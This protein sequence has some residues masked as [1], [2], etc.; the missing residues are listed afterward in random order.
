MTQPQALG[1][2]ESVLLEREAELEAIDAA[3]QRALAGDGSL[4]V[5]AGHAGIGKSALLGAARLRAQAV[6]VDALAARGSQLERELSFGL[7][8][9]LFEPALARAPTGEREELLSGA[10]GLAASLFYPETAAPRLNEDQE[11]AYLHG[12]HWLCAN[13]SEQA[14]LLILADDAHWA[15]RLSLRFLL[16]LA[17]RL[18]DLPVTV[19]LALRPNEPEAAVDLLLELCAHPT[20]QVLRLAPLGDAAV[21]SL[22]KAR[23][24]T[25]E[26]L[27]WQACARASSG[28]PFLLG[29]LL[30]AVEGASILPVAAE[31]SRV[32]RLAPD[33]VL[34]AT[35]ARL[36][37][38]PSEAVALVHA[39]AVLG[40]GAEPRHAAALSRLTLPEAA[41]AADTLAAIEILRPGQPL[42]FVHPLVHASVEAD[43]P[44]G[45]RGLLHL[46]AA[47][48][49]AG[50]IA[51]AR[52]AQHLLAAPATN[53]SWVV[54]TLREAAVHALVT[55]APAT[56][57]LYLRRALDEP[58]SPEQKRAVLLE[59]GEA[60]ALAGEPAALERFTDALAL[61]RDASERARTLL[62]LG[63]MLH[64]AGKLVE[65][66]DAFRRGL[67]ELAGEDEELER[68]LTIGYLGVAWLDKS[69]TQDLIQRRKALLEARGGPESAAERSILAQVLLQK[70]FGGEPHQEVRQLGERVL[71]EGRLLAEE[72]S[73]ALT[74]WIA[75]GCLSWAD[76]L[77]RAEAAIE[78][79]FEDA[80]RRGALLDTAL[81]IYSRSWPRLWRGRISDAAADAQAAVDAWSGGWGMYLPAAKYW[82]AVALLELDDLDGADA[83]LTLPDD[84]RWRASAM[85]AIW[86]VGRGRVATAKGQ[87]VVAWDELRAAGE[88]VANDLL[89]VN[90][91]V[92]PWR[93]E[94][95]LAGAWVG[96]QKEALR[97]AAE[98]VELA[99]RFG[100]ARPLG[101]ALRAAGLVEGGPRGIDLLREAV[102]TLEA[103]PSQLEYARALVDL[104]A[105]LRRQGTRAEAREPLRQGL[106][107]AERFGARR[108]ERQAR[109]ELEASGARL[110]R[111]AL[112]GVASLTPSERR[113][114]E[115]AAEGMSNR[116]IAQALFVTVKAVKFHLHNAY[117]KL[118]IASRA[119][120]PEALSD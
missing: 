37:R 87:A 74:L 54:E 90:P 21:E 102:A 18:E 39:V 40:D 34:R 72:G 96:E 46:Q 86:L 83:A 78:A 97:L 58:P 11:F 75:I 1:L 89:I 10:A 68:E 67:D 41:K 79:A 38:L 106:A 26:D 110:R 94:A 105:A 14:P 117:G 35:I 36:A 4:L 55:A 48:L 93:S 59:L 49:L 5:V 118:D 85:Y 82:L 15:D 51:A 53:D 63:W 6:A 107:M 9:Q 76:D 30:S 24:P 101:V 12:L 52:V 3:L 57:A 32:E 31:A 56:A 103:S 98:E 19:M 112:S 8:L 13:L 69:L 84:D 119:A 114:A 91:A 95:A 100:A 25:A 7:A 44:P 2:R 60:E 116:E 115:M 47:K 33:A 77:D 61:I 109:A 65:A 23:M 28:N 43:L 71:D 120:L 99:R 29:E 113:V 88:L 104:G 42:A 45:E 64:K 111:T 108:L 62:R 73:D 81:A 50:D 17:K 20:A 16:Y 22:V 80:R 66:A 70:M 92:I 27:F